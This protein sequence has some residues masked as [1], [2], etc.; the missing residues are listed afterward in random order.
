M[1]KVLAARSAKKRRVLKPHSFASLI[2]FSKLLIS[3][4]IATSTPRR[5]P[6]CRCDRRRRKCRHPRPRA[7]AGRSRT[8]ANAS[9]GATATRPQMP[10]LGDRNGASK[11]IYWQDARMPKER[12]SRC[13]KWIRRAVTFTPSRSL[14]PRWAGNIKTNARC[15]ILLQ[16]IPMITSG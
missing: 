3:P 1:L 7:L 9:P 15:W 4:S 8:M 11:R 12:P 13:D 6:S 5:S 10:T 2:S 16:Q 14:A